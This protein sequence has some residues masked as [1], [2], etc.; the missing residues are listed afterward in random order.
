MKKV[1]ISKFNSDFIIINKAGKTDY[2]SRKYAFDNLQ[3]GDYIL[4]K[5]G[6]INVVIDPGK[7]GMGF[8]SAPGTGK[9]RTVTV[10]EVEFAEIQDKIKGA[11]YHLANSYPSSDICRK[12]LQQG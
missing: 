2:W 7:M 12:V 6:E 3:E 1:F 8:S 4:W 5:D 9:W 10:K 11:I